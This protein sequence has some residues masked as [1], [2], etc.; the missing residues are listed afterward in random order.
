MLLVT[1]RTTTIRF[2]TV[3]V[4]ATTY[5]ATF[6]KPVASIPIGAVRQASP[7]NAGLSALGSFVCGEDLLRMRV[8]ERTNESAKG[9]HVLLYQ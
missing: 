2:A 7:C 4:T 6:S 8:V 1:I 9:L 5:V 3:T